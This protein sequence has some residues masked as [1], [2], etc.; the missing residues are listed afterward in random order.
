MNESVRFRVHWHSKRKGREGF[1]G[2]LILIHQ[3]SPNQC[4]IHRVELQSMSISLY[5]RHLRE[6][7]DVDLMVSA[8]QHIVRQHTPEHACET[9]F[10]LSQ[11]IPVIVSSRS[12]A[13]AVAVAF[14][15]PMP[16][17]P[18]IARRPVPPAHSLMAES[19]GQMKT[20]IA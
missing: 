11:P 12:S 17:S 14:P 3:V 5:K 2:K 1:E 8:I 4:V 15:P 19:V 18:A 7:Q 16:V 6:C 10:C 9:P 13:H 20:P